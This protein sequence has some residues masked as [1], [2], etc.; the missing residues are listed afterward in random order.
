MKATKG[1]ADPTLI[2]RLLKRMLETD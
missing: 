2:N 1:K